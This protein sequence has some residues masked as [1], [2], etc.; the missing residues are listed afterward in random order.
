MIWKSKQ[1]I[2]GLVVPVVLA[3][4]LFGMGIAQLD[5]LEG[6]EAPDDVEGM[7]CSMCH[8]EFAT[9]YKYTHTPAFDAECTLCHLETG[10][11]GH[12]GLTMDGRELC[13][14]CHSEQEYHYPVQTCWT[15][16]CH[17]DKHG[18][19]IDEL[20]NPSRQEC[21]PGFA[22]STLGACYVGSD[23]CLGCH[24]D[25]QEWWAE[26]AHSLPDMDEKARDGYKGCEGC[27][28]PG[29]NHMG[30]LAGI[31]VFDVATVEEADAMCFKC[32]RDEMFEPDYW[33]TIHPLA[34][35][36]CSTCHNPHDVT[37][38]YNLTKP[39]NE[40]CISCHETKRADFNRMSHHPVDL[41]DPRTGMRCAECHDPHGAGGGRMLKEPL[42]ELCISCHVDKGGP[43]VYSH[44]GYDPAMGRG[45]QTCHTHHGS[46]T[47]NLLMMN[48]R[49][50][51][52]QCHTDRA[53]HMSGQ[54]CWT[55]GCHTEHH[56]SNSNFFFFN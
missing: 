39:A 20:F 11:G 37:N 48:G 29:S 21:Y 51:C 30:R 52:I 10:E 49:G 14:Q 26:S 34:G 25:K 7:E 12:G 46:N 15:S 32:H 41:K 55:T 31:G 50:V 38:E 19:D 35:V 2:F 3:A 47:P 36:A 8:G 43:Y 44:P 33:K 16:T 9:E 53:T 6:M 40:L 17:A 1:A 22:E 5:G 54:T 42:E 23:T 27:H 4:L 56:G 45:C 13:L 18:S 28:G 24:C